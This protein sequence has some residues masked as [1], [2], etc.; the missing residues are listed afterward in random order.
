M[1]KRAEN[2]QRQRKA[3]LGAAVSVFSQKGF[4]K[5][6]VGE[7]ARRAG[8]GKGTIYLY[9]EDKSQLFAAAVAEGIE[10]IIKQLRAEL[11]SDLPFLQHIQKLVEKNVSLYLEYSDLTSIFQNELSKSIERGTRRQ[12][13]QARQ[14]Y[15]DFISEILADGHRRGYLRKVDFDLAA[16]G[17]VGVLDALCNYQLHHPERFS[18][19]IIIDTLFTLLSSGLIDRDRKARTRGERR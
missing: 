11:E 1:G 13:E 19:K 6:E 14:R 12:I 17:I 15:L 10:S 2:S 3:I 9:F 5:A 4:H 8:V 16:V 7:I 18:K